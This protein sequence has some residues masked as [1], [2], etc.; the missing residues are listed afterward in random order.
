MTIKDP[1]KIW[2][3]NFLNSEKYKIYLSTHPGSNILILSYIELNKPSHHKK[4]FAGRKTPYLTSVYARGRS[5]TSIK[6]RVI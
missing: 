3:S 1:N 5:F 6:S 4:S 2:L